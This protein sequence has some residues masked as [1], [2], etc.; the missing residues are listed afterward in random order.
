MIS[1]NMI[2]DMKSSEKEKEK[3]YTWVN[4]YTHLE[5]GKEDI[6]IYNVM[7]KEKKTRDI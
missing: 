6:Y 7:K 2:Y 3:H 4:I 5:M 1:Y